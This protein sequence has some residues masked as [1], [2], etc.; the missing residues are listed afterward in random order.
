M[1]KTKLR[2]L[3]VG[4]ALLLLITAAAFIIPGT[5]AKAASAVWDGSVATGYA[6]GSGTEE[7]PYIIKTAPQLA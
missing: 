7:D 4:L 3:S 5:K 6:S 2:L 1:V